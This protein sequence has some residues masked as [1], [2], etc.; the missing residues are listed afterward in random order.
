MQERKRRLQTPRSGKDAV[1]RKRA[2]EG[3]TVDQANASLRESH[4]ILK[5]TAEE[6]V[7]AA[8]ATIACAEGWMEILCTQ[9]NSRKTL[10]KFEDFCQPGWFRCNKRHELRHLRKGR[11]ALRG[12]AVAHGAIESGRHDA[13]KGYRIYK[14]A[15][16]G[17]LDSLE[18]TVG[19]MATAATTR[20]VIEQ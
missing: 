15:A 18:A 20:C 11:G 1:V 10:D 6:A 9:T 2:P 17:D 4:L 16:D 12:V 19:R 14:P 3:S 7:E 8:N 13:G 5:G